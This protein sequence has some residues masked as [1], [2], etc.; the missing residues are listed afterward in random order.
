LDEE[1][2]TYAGVGQENSFSPAYLISVLRPE[3]AQ[4]ICSPGREECNKYDLTAAP[5]F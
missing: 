2:L 3:K 4:Q 5:C 1:K